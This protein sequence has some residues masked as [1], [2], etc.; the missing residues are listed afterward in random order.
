[1]K[2]FNRMF[3]YAAVLTALAIFSGCSEEEDQPDQ[4]IDIT[5]SAEDLETSSPGEY[6]YQVESGN[7][8]NISARI[9]STVGLSSMVITKTVNNIIDESY[10]TNGT[11]TVD[12]SGNEASFDFAYTPSVDDVD[13]LV[14]FN[15]KG[16]NSNG[17]MK[18][19]DLQLVVT[20]SPIDNLPRRRW[21][22]TS[23]FHVN[24]DEEAIKDCEKDNSMLLNE[25]GS[26]VFDFGPDTAQG[27][28]AFD[29]FTVYNKWY[30]TEE[31][32]V[33]YFNREGYGIF[34]PETI[35]VDTYKIVGLTTEKM[36]MEQT[37]DLSDFGESTEETF[38]FTY[39]AMPR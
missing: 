8:V 37:M 1:M 20:L 22:L 5:L 4:S 7:E 21:L 16:T 6:R 35:V 24:Q 17:A 33:Q 28:C 30:I 18:E 10:G 36:E 14:G 29:G 23:V 34:A 25:D 38:I 9:Q 26:M 3:K 12:V 32:G 15:F 13:Q 19:I 39:V 31:D 11:A 27:D 2:L